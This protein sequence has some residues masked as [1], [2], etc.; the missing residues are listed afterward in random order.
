MRGRAEKAADEEQQHS[1]RSDQETELGPLVIVKLQV[2]VARADSK[3]RRGAATVHCGCVSLLGSRGGNGRG[4]R[5]PLT[6]SGW[7]VPCYAGEKKAAL[8]PFKPVKPEEV[9]KIKVRRRPKR[10]TSISYV[11]VWE[12]GTDGFCCG[13]VVGGCRRRWLRSTMCSSPT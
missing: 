5:R 10:K 2:W 1:T 4:H 8:D 6:G 3:A 11:A 7:P 12:G 13:C 9:Q